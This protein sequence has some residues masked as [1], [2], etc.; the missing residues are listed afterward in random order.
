MLIRSDTALV[1]D[2]VHG[3]TSAKGKIENIVNVGIRHEVDSNG[4]TLIS[5]R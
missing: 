3:A 4:G 5:K 2:D 1:V